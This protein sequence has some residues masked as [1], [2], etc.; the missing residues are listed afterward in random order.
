MPPCRDA[1]KMSVHLWPWVDTQYVTVI[2]V[3]LLFPS[4]LCLHGLSS[5]HP[6]AIGGFPPP[7]FQLGP[8]EH[9]G[10]TVVRHSL[11]LAHFSS[12][13]GYQSLA[14]IVVPRTHMVE[15]KWH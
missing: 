14:Q 7:F 3:C 15:G 6:R 9:Q 10:H 12:S 11:L 2:T 8:A 1:L 4:L 13:S 5:W